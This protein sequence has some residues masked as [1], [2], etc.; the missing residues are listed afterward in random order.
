MNNQ[1]AR[2]IATSNDLSEL[3]L[4]V[5]GA[6]RPVR[7]RV[8]PELIP[9]LAEAARVSRSAIVVTDAE[10]DAPGPTILW[11]NDAFE[12][13]TG[14]RADEVVGQSPR[15]LQG[16]ATDRRVLDRL[17]YLVERGQD[18]E[19]EA[20]NYRADGTPFVMS[21]RTS[22]IRGPDGTATHFVGIQ[23][24][25][26]AQRLHASGDR[27]ATLALQEVLLPSLPRRIGPFEVGHTYRPADFALIGGDWVDVIALPHGSK[28]LVVVGDV[29]GH[30]ARAVATMGQLR[31]A[32]QA[33]ALAGLTLSGVMATL[34]RLAA[35]Q[36]LVATLLLVVLDETGKLEYLCAGHPPA[37]IV[38]TDGQVRELAT[39]APLIGVTCAG[40]DRTAAGQMVAGEVLVAYTDGLIERRGH[41]LDEGLTA[42]RAA[43]LRLVTSHP[44]TGSQVPPDT[45]AR[46]IVDAMT[47]DGVGEDDIALVTLCLGPP[48]AAELT[49][50][51]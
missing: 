31:W 47:A 38:G 34:R 39:T 27:A 35:L 6:A 28:T 41:D 46:A 40:P 24:D 1:D 33:A 3:V 4:Q 20:I 5:A 30:G 44:S 48:L 25:V 7:D 13:I 51:P 19:G 50:D 14:Y 42:L 37:L 17:R 2:I 49:C 23:D 26:T 21:W 8:D 22:A 16:P 32:T 9:L 10:L 43:A 45:L 29:T 18:F 36:D 11:V 12:R 15:L